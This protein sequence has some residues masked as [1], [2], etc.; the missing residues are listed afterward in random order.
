MT[1]L[2]LPVI[3]LEVCFSRGA[4][5]IP[6]RRTLSQMHQPQMFVDVFFELFVILF[7]DVKLFFMLL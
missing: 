2:F 7:V 1:L 5:P 6:V 4:D 3:V